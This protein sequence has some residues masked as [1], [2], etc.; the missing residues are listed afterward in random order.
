MCRPLGPRR[1]SVLAI[2][3]S[4]SQVP[5]SE[6]PAPFR[7][8]HGIRILA[9]RAAAP[10]EPAKSPQRLERSA[11]HTREAAAG[12][13]FGCTEA[14]KTSYPRKD[15]SPAFGFFFLVTRSFFQCYT[16][17]FCRFHGKTL[18]KAFEKSLKV[19]REVHVLP[20]HSGLGNALSPRTAR[21][22]SAH[23]CQHPPAHPHPHPRYCSAT[24]ENK[25]HAAQAADSNPRAR[26]WFVSRGDQSRSRTLATWLWGRQVRPEWQGSG[27][28]SLSWANNSCCSTVWRPALPRR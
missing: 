16:H 13:A 21:S 26:P 12:L 18:S 7:P 11:D 14:F 15:L 4:G 2:R 10:T 28:P 19:L 9:H 17:D 1:H 23:R 8:A 22:R 3:V 6:E 25:F 27:S 20:A 24:S 5:C